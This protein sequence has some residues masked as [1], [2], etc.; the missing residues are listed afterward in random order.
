MTKTP[1]QARV[2]ANQMLA[3]LYATVTDWNEAVLDQ[4]V[5]AIAGGNR[6]FSANDLWAIV[7]DMGR[8]A[9][10]LYFSGLVRRSHPRVLLKVGDEP[11]VN[12]KAHG[13]PVYL[14]LLTAE[15]RK[16]LEDRRNDRAEQRKQ[17]AA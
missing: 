2:D 7:P 8:G 15:G 17:A 12:P 16:F 14:Y 1:E 9:A 3:A 11:S 4:A 10:G 5:L 13:K 6:P